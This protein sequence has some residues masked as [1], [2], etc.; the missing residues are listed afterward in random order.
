MIMK[1]GMFEGSRKAFGSMGL[2]W[3]RIQKCTMHDSGGVKGS[4]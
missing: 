4:V 3:V 2:F 1:E